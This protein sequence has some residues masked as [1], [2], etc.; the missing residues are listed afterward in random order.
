M[1]I[2]SKPLP[3]IGITMGDPAGIGP[4][5]IIKA[6]SSKGIL[7]ICRPVVFG[8][9]AIL[10]RELK[11]LKNLLDTLNLYL[12]VELGMIEN[13]DEVESSP[14]EPIEEDDDDIPSLRDL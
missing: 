4:E 14:V 12:D 10:Q 6:L 7:N 11:E 8:D 5:I 3:I 9:Q 13:P 2:N 1:G